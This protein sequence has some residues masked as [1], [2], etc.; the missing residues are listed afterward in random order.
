MG[1]E[2]GFE[3]VG[4]ELVGVDGAHGGRDED[5]CR[6]RRSARRCVDGDLDAANAML[7]RPHEVRGVVVDGDKR[8]RELGFPTANVARARRRSACRP[9]ASTPAGTRVPTAC[10]A[11]AAISL[12]R[13]PTF[14]DDADRSLLEAHLLDFDGDLYGERPGCGSCAAC[15]TS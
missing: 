2:L 11:P 3:V 15:A 10:P 8:A 5:G 1:A 7:G 9:T 12:G 13:R 14:Y 4:I 6:R